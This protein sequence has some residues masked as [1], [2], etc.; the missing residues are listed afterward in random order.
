M[1]SLIDD[2]AVLAEIA[3]AVFTVNYAMLY[4]IPL[5]NPYKKSC[6]DFSD[7]MMGALLLPQLLHQISLYQDA[8]QRHQLFLQYF[9]YLQI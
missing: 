6:K 4:Q 1:A 2:N 3:G 8:P 9:H 7:R 5:R